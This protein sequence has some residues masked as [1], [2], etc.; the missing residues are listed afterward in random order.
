MKEKDFQSLFNKWVKNVYKKTAVFELKQ[1]TK[2]SIPFSD[3]APHQIEALQSA[4][5]RGFVFKIPDCGYQSP[6]DAF[7]VFGVPAFVVIKYPKR[8][9]MI[10]IDS[11][12]LE[13]ERS[14]RKSLTAD[15]AHEI[16]TT[17]L[18]M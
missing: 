13:R 14:K 5:H 11:F 1:T 2:D 7:A 6:F 15:R 4:R 16:S 8:T 18:K 9:E 3:V 10:S 17:T 12:L